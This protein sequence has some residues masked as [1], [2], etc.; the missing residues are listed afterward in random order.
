MFTTMVEASI[1][2]ITVLVGVAAT[3]P[4]MSLVSAKRA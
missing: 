1:A 2:I 3:L 4:T